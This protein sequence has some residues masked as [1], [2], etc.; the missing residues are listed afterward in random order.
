MRIYSKYILDGWDGGLPG[1]VDNWAEFLK[2]RVINIWKD[3]NL[4]NY[5]ENTGK[6]FAG[7]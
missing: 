7:V 3:K 6:Y 5:F 1:A 2:E 4:W